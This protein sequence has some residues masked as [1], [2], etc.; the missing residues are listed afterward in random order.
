MDDVRLTKG[1]ASVVAAWAA[2]AA[3]GEMSEQTLGRFSQLLERFGKFAAARGASDLS[4]VTPTVASMF[5]DAHGHTRHGHVAPAALATRHLRRSVLRMLYST[6]RDLALADGDPTQHLNLPTRV[7][8]DT[9]PL[10]EAEAV[11]LRLAAEFTDRPSR[12]AAAAA[13]ALAGGFSG[14]IG[15]TG[16]QHLDL[17][18]RRVWVHGSSKTRPRWC[19]LDDWAIRVLTARSK[20]VTATAAPGQDPLTLRLAVSSRNGSDEQIQARVCVAL[21]D[22]LKAIGLGAD[23]AVRPASVTAYAG[24]E[25]FSVTR[26]IEAVARH[27]GMTSLDSAA[28]LIGYDWRAVPGHTDP[29]EESRRAG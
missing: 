5:I 10:N 17:P 9:R 26:R 14:E 23:T 15:H 6:A 16:P 24:W 3:R 25:T 28:D 2:M 8:G 11:A 13:L 18:S 7:T 19:H 29:A 20:H 21:R 4:D 22:L 27:L 12:H 1:I